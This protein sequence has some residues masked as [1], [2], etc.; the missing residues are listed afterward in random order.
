MCRLLD[1]MMAERKAGHWADPTVDAEGHESG[2]GSFVHALP[3]NQFHDV[4][5]PVPHHARDG[6]LKTLRRAGQILVRPFQDTAA[7]RVSLPHGLDSLTPSLG[8]RD[9]EVFQARF[10][11]DTDLLDLRRCSLECPDDGIY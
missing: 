1:A 4:A 2:L 11:R 7:G 9:D 6:F 10:H 8:F 5:L 3:S